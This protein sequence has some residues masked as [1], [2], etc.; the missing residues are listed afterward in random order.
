VAAGGRDLQS[1]LGVFLPLDFGKIHRRMGQLRGKGDLAGVGRHR[2]PA[3]QVL[4][5][6]FQ[7]IDGVHGH[8]G[9]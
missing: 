4:H 8:V 6:V 2:L 3:P 5:Q 1:P 7:G 9:Q